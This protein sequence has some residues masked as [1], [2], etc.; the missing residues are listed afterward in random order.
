MVLVDKYDN[1]REPGKY[2]LAPVG[3]KNISVHLV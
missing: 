3:Y 1:L 2:A